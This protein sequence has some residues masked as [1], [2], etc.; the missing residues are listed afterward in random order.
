MV[1]ALPED[2]RPL[3]RAE[4]DQLVAL[5]VF[6]DE[7]IELLDGVLIPM[8]PIGPRRPR[9]S[10]SERRASVLSVTARA[11]ESR[12]HLQ[13]ATSRNPSQIWSSRRLGIM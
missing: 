7:R 2:F 1:T 12:I 11:F 6:G 10:I 3:R 5:G 13:R 4:Y 9:P 8:S